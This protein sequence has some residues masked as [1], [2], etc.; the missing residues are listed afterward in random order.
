MDARDVGNLHV[1]CANQSIKHD[2]FAFATLTYIDMYVL[3]HVIV[4]FCARV[5]NLHI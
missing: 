3:I 5:F 1:F 2:M 4:A